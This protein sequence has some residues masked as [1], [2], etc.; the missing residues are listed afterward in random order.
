MDG[1][2]AR[3]CFLLELQAVALPKHPEVNQVRR[4]RLKP[5]FVE[6]GQ[7]KLLGLLPQVVEPAA[8]PVNN[9]RGVIAEHELEVLREASEGEVGAS[10]DYAVIG[11]VGDECLA[12]EEP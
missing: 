12:V 9:V 2:A 11:R 3:R 6:G 5:G 4:V 10:G 8:N 1:A 7:V